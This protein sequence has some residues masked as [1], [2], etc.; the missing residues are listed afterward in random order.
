[1]VSKE[2]SIILSTSSLLNCLPGQFIK[3]L[4]QVG[5]SSLTGLGSYVLICLLLKMDE[6]NQLVKR[7]KK[8]SV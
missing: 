4:L 6:I 3:L 5:I 8:S 2:C 7:I 1:V